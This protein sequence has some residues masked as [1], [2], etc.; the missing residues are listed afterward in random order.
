MQ[1]DIAII[2]LGPAGATLARLLSPAYRVIAI[3]KKSAEPSAVGFQKP[4]GGLLAKDAQKALSKYDLTL[5]KDVL[6]DPQIFAVKTVDTHQHLLRHYQRFYINLDRHKFD[7]WL[8][9]LIPDTV[10]VVKNALC[11][12]IQK[13]GDLYEVCYAEDGQQTLITAKYVIGADGANSIVR[14]QLFRDRKPRQYISIQQWFAEENKSPFY[15]SIFDSD[16]TDSYCWSISK[17]GYFILGGAF[18]LHHAR[19]RFELLKDKL[20]AHGFIFNEPTKTE[21]CLVNM[22]KSFKDFYTGS[23]NVFLL[24]EAAGFISP[25]SLE[26][27]SYALD[28]AYKLAKILNERPQ[29]AGKQYKAAVLPIKVKLSMKWLK[30]P[31]MY[32]PLL[33]KLVMKSGITSIPVIETV[34]ENSEAQSTHTNKTDNQGLKK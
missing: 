22:P 7:L 21:A 1:Y 23:D 10:K 32:W 6:V 29:Y 4:C 13:H 28:S 24:G 18:P 33:R 25:S 12:R 11:K 34:A 15:S 5:P 27:I 30:R 16:V 26:G 14:R 20:I 8:M 17:D 9:S 19:Q 31:F 3:D 2:G